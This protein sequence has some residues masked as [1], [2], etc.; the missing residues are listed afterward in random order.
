MFYTVAPYMQEWL[1]LLWEM[2]SQEAFKTLMDYASGARPDWI[3]FTLP[4]LG[5]LNDVWGKAH[6]FILGPEMCHDAAINLAYDL[7]KSPVLNLN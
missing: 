6:T 1:E 7:I 2:P 3:N 5:Q 4:G